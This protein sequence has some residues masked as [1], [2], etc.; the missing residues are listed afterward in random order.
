M[1]L[2]QPRCF[3]Q[4]LGPFPQREAR[5]PQAVI[6]EG[7]ERPP[8]KGLVVQGKLSPGHFRRPRHPGQCLCPPNQVLDKILGPPPAWRGPRPEARLV[9]DCTLPG[10]GGGAP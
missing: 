6:R 4:D 5:A 2:D 9:A 3:A 10:G 7:R 8:H 1:A